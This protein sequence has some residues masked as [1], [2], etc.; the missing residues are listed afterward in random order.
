VATGCGFSYGALGI[1]HHATEDLSIMRAL[2]EITCVAPGDLWE[3]E[4]ATAAIAELPGTC[5]LRLDKSSAP[6]TATIFT[7]AR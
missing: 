4:E 7:F 3:T 1:S 5:Y 2:P 6:P